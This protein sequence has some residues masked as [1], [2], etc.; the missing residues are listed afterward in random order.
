[1][2]LINKIVN[3]IHF[4][5]NSGSSDSCEILA[6]LDDILVSSVD[7][8]S[9]L[10]MLEVVLNKFETE[11]LKLNMK[12]CTFLQTRVTYL[13]HEISENGVQPAESKLTA[14]SQFPVPKNVH[15]VRQF[16]GLCSYFRKFIHKFA[17][18]IGR[19]ARI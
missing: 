9:G 3:S 5:Q 17:R 18:L 10:D 19:F 1:M 16:I 14:V 13:G 2:R 8:Q 4:S 11:N 12:K 6:F 15:E 7:V